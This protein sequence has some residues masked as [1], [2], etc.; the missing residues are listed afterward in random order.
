M[1]RSLWRLLGGEGE[2]L[3][4]MIERM[5]EDEE[6]DIVVKLHECWYGR[7]CL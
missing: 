5:G 3:G 6:G 2:S 1:W 7:G 4:R